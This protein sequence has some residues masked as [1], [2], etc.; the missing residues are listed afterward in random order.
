MSTNFGYRAENF[1]RIQHVQNILKNALKTIEKTL[2]EKHTSLMTVQSSIVHPFLNTAI[3]NLGILLRTRLDHD[4][5]IFLLMETYKILHLGWM[6]IHAADTLLSETFADLRQRAFLLLPKGTCVNVDLFTPQQ[7]PA[8]STNQS[9]MLSTIAHWWNKTV[10]GRGEQGRRSLDHQS[11]EGLN[12]AKSS[13]CAFLQ[14]ELDL[15]SVTP[16]PSQPQKLAPLLAPPA[17]KHP[18]AS[19]WSVGDRVIVQGGRAGTIATIQ[20]KKALIAWDNGHSWAYSFGEMERYKYHKMPPGLSN[21]EL[22][23][24]Q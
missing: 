8:S 11:L 7:L 21:R 14:L 1:E 22:E 10:L 9:R 2:K 18:S 17:E 13:P 24:S 19:A 16:A 20:G 12:N 3:R 4:K 5:V 23:I 6:R 15:E